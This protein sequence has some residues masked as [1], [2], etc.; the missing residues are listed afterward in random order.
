MCQ[1]GDANKSVLNTHPKYPIIVI[2][3]ILIN[4]ITY[5][6][7]AKIFL[8]SKQKLKAYMDKKQVF[9]QNKNM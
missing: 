6:V 7:K 8:H 5:I 9:C 3:L 2:F 4:I 1:H